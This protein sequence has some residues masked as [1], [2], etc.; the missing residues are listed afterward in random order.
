M[1]AEKIKKTN[2]G[3]F[4]A[5]TKSDDELA[6]FVTRRDLLGVFVCFFFIY[7]FGFF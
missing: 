6:L 2:F 4:A 1:I 3:F 7:F 5:K